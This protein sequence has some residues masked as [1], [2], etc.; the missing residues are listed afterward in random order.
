MKAK[1]KTTETWVAVTSPDD[2]FKHGIDVDFK[3]IGCDK[4]LTI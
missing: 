3:Q 4:I 2:L 1:L